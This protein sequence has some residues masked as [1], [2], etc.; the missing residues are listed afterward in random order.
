MSEFLTSKIIT[1]VLFYVNR[2]VRFI[3]VAE[4]TGNITSRNFLF[5]FKK[6]NFNRIWARNGTYKGNVDVGDE[7]VGFV[8]HHI[9]IIYA[10]KNIFPLLYY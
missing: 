6:N 2:G 5:F 8:K 7:V 10:S 4:K 1:T 3:V 9:Y